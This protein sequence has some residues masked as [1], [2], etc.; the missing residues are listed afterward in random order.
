MD[1]D[2]GVRAPVLGRRAFLSRAMALGLG[3]GVARAA[4]GNEG[5]GRE[6]VVLQTSDLTALDPHG[7]TYS[8]DCR[9]S[10]NVFDTLVRRHPDGTLNPALATSWARTGPTTWRLTLRRGVRWHDGTPFTSTDAKYSLD[11]IYDGTVKAAR[12]RPVFQTI[13]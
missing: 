7:S 13:A 1:S 10:F 5:S 12:L 6:L 4:A 11:R 9:V 2:P 8:S 3:A